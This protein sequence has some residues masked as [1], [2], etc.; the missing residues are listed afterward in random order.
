MPKIVKISKFVTVIR[1]E[2][3]FFFPTRFMLSESLNLFT[4]CF[5]K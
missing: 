3:D 2:V 1:E 4:H 5:F